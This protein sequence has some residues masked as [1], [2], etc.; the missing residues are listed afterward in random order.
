MLVEEIR[1]HSE[2]GERFRVDT[3]PGIAFYFHGEETYTE[4]YDFCYEDEIPTGNVIMIMVGDDYKHIVDP[5]DVSPLSE[6]EYC[7]ECGQI[8]CMHDAR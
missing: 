8:G 6:D 4:G 1:K 3:Y 7:H 5:D 2:E